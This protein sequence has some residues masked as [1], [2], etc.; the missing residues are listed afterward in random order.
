[1]TTGSNATQA[2]K[3]WEAIRADPSIQFAPPPPA[4]APKQ[5]EVPEWLKSLG[6]WLGDWL[7]PVGRWLAMNWPVLKWVL[8]GI[9]VL[10]LALVAWHLL[11][12][13]LDWR[14]RGRNEAPEWT[15]DHDEALALLEDADAL[16]AAG[17][18]DEATHLLLI[19][20]VGQIR[21]A[22][23]DWLEPSSTAREIA[24][25]PSLPERARAAFGT[26]AERVE[27]SLFALRKLEAED[28]H[29][30]RAAYADFALARIDGARL[31]GSIA[32]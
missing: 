4:A 3:H 15:P 13:L 21:A 19:R 22:R 14:P 11:K 25:L 27:R 10:C 31:D 7:G 1:M 18:F 24:A 9:A 26:I 32:R 2:A 29:A 20:S 6:E 30:A 5:P 23:P 17:R 12:P 28:W 8:I 16:A